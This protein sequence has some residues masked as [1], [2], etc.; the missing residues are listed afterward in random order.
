MFHDTFRPVYNRRGLT[1]VLSRADGEEVFE[2]GNSQRRSRHGRLRSNR[3]ER[4][5]DQPHRHRYQVGGGK[6][7]CFAKTL[8]SQDS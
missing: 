1:H 3:T 6:R 5:K 7:G 8:V 2:G 4:P